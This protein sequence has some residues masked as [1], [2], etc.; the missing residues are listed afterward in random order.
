MGV[1]WQEMAII[2]VLLL[3]VVGPERLPEVAYHV[4]R[5]VRRMQL[6]A[7]VVRDE[8]RGE[9]E[10]LETE[11]KTLQGELN[12]TS[13]ELREQQR[14]LDAEFREST[15]EIRGAARSVEESVQ[16]PRSRNGRSTVPARTG[17][18]SSARNG[19]APSEATPPKADDAP[20][21]PRIF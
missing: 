21:K 12:E 3:V 14:A 7:R 11:Y 15:D 18:T 17:S 19:T 13:A 9:F 2:V 5:W 4:G 20:S 6:Y 1:G 8:F 16:E 10:Y